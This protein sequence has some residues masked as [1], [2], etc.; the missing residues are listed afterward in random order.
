MR[1]QGIDDVVGSWQGIFLPQGTPAS[2]IE[3]LF[4]VAQKTMNDA[5]VQQHLAKG[6]VDVV[7]SRSPEDFT[8][9]VR[10]ENARYAAV[11]SAAH[12]ATAD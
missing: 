8:A 1:E 9:F 7:L 10:G 3:R 12:I 5:V 11:I 6:G 2:I 4:R